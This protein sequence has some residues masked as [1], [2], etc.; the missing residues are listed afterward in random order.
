MIVAQSLTEN[1]VH[2]G[3]Q[4]EPLLE[5]VDSDIDTFCGDGA[6]DQWKVHNLLEDKEIEAIIPPRK[7]AKIKQHGNTSDHPLPRDEAIRGIRDQGRQ[8]WKESVGYHQR[9]LAE[10]AMYRMKNTFGDKLKNRK[11]VNQVNEA[12]IR[13][14][15][16]NLFVTLGMPVFLWT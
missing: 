13:C 8:A 3:D 6:Y 4:V 12:A 2:D 14:K 5:Q 7:N 11:I 1:N 15:I 10:T 16:L 9:S